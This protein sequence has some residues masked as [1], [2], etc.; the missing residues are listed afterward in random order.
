[1]E[2]CGRGPL[3]YELHVFLRAS[4]ATLA[5]QL[6]YLLA[7][8][9]ILSLERHGEGVE[10]AGSPWSSGLPA[11]FSAM[12]SCLHGVVKKSWG[13]SLLFLPHASAFSSSHSLSGAELH[14]V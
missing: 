8:L 3:T 1:M 14:L 9:R 2:V 10:R 12:C 5:S 7:F 11:E 6:S 4:I 13:F